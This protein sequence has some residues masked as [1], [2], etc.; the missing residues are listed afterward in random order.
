MK[1]SERLRNR[2]LA[3]KAK[4]GFRGYPV[5]TI[6]FYGP[7]N[8][9]ATKVAVGVVAA[10]GDEPSMRRWLGE[11][12]DIR[13]DQEVF[14][15][16][17]AHLKDHGVKSVS[18]MKGIFGCPHEEGVDYPEDG[19]CPHCPYWKGRDRYTGELEAD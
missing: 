1:L 5:G 6:A 19:F 15:E 16:V 4:G 9:R 3:K 12:G 2:W 11:E 10:E 17:A 8:E 14:N 18:M 13:N 7:D